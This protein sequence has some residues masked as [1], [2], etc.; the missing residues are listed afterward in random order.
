MRKI[1][2][3]KSFRARYGVVMPFNGFANDGFGSFKGNEFAYAKEEVG[4]G[5]N[6]KD[7]SDKLSVGRIADDV[8]SFGVKCEVFVGFV[9]FSGFELEW[10]DGVREGAAELGGLSNVRVNFVVVEESEE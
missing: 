4:L 2:D 5:S 8:E 1:G 6:V 9:Y 7:M 3:L 10:R